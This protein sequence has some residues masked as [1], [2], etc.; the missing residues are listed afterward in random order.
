M[1]LKR[2]LDN[3][4]L[5]RPEASLVKDTLQSKVNVNLSLATLSRHGD[6][7]RSQKPRGLNVKACFHPSSTGFVSRAEL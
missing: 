2:R 7:R 6:Y 4:S 5:R 3:F 1:S